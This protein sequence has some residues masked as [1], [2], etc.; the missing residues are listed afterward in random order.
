MWNNN[1]MDNFYDFNEDFDGSTATY[2]QASAIMQQS[3]DTSVTGSAPLASAPSAVSS[4][5]VRNYFLFTNAC[6]SVLDLVPY[7]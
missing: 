1:A 4:A 6:E 3:T 5:L 7:F 2:R